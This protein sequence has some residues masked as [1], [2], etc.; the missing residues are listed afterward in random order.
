[1]GMAVVRQ[2][3]SQRPEQLALQVPGGWDSL[4][5]S[6][7]HRTDG[8]CAPQNSRS[9]WE[10]SGKATG[11]EPAAGTAPSAW[12]FSEHHFPQPQNAGKWLPHLTV[13]RG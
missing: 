5:E 4:A 3:H 1:M 9:R 12:G 6:W 11:P 7:L 2:L 8:G 13:K 10:R